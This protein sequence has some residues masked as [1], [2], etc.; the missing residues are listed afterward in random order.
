MHGVLAKPLSI[1][2]VIRAVTFLCSWLMLGL[3]WVAPRS[4]AA[5]A[6]VPRDSR[7]NVLVIVA[8]DLGYSDLGCFGSEISTPNLDWLAAQ[9]TTFTNFHTAATCSPTRAMLLTGVDHHLAGMGGMYEYIWQT[10]EQIGQ[11][12]YEGYL[13]DRV[14]TIAEVLGAAG[15]HTSIAGKWHLGA[16]P[17]QSPR[18]RGFTRSWVLLDGSAEHFEPSPRRRFMSDGQRTAYPYGTYSSTW[19]TD[20]SISFV[21]EACAQQRPFLLVAAYTAPHWP[22]QAP[23]Q[24]IEKYRNVYDAGYDELL[25]RRVEQL[26]KRGIVPVG[27]PVAPAP[28]L[29]PQMDQ[30]PPTVPFVPWREL[31]A[32]Q[33]QY[34]ARLMEVYAAM[35]E[36]LDTEIGRLLA[37]LRQMEQLENTLIIFLSDNGAESMEYPHFAFDP[38]NALENLGNSDSFVGYGP[39]WARASSGPFR[40]LKGYPTEGGIRTPCI[41]KLPHVQSKI[42]CSEFVSVLDLAPTIY[43]LTNSTHPREFRGRTVLPLM[44]ASMMSLLQGKTQRVHAPDYGMGW[45]LFGRAAYRKGDWKI[46]WVERPFGQS[47][48]ELFNLQRDPGETRDLKQS[49]AA[50]YRDLVDAWNEY[51]EQV[52]VVLARP[53]HW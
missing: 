11:P 8:D 19:Y 30:V 12:G 38:G 28:R 31:R 7:P 27:I 2:R 45:E 17:G 41:V 24:F 1:T 49:E 46:V 15:Y 44:G 48:F 21:E 47:D 42:V 22:L 34:A 25:S 18:Y 52:G 26:Q 4:G 53:D 32:S 36:C 37:H 10:R 5:A 33:Q 50:I 51:A 9:G 35:V 13:N 40:L 29:R 14:V 23:R 20:K 39:D 16:A 3:V 43:E 6:N